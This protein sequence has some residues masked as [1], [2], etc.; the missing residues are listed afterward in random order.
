MGKSLIRLLPTYIRSRKMK[1]R[2]KK[3]ETRN[4]LPPERPKI[5]R[6]VTTKMRNQ[7]SHKITF[8][9]GMYVLGSNLTLKV[10]KSL[11]TLRQEMKEELKMEIL[12]TLSNE[13]HTEID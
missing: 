11:K 8:T 12:N 9:K 13:I 2:I 5:P 1:D 3:T 7:K 4:T 10:T 6:R